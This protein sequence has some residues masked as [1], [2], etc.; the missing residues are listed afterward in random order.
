M[1]TSIYSAGTPLSFFNCQLISQ[2]SLDTHRSRMK[3][4]RCATTP[5]ENVN[6]HTHRNSIVTATVLHLQCACVCL[7][8]CHIHSHSNDTVEHMRRSTSP[9]ADCL[10]SRFVRARMANIVLI[11]QV[12]FNTGAVVATVLWT[13]YMLC[14]SITSFSP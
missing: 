14:S 10:P 7:Y 1:I 9:C 2:S 4:L 11:V 6:S 12:M 3:V 13:C 8:F 5:R